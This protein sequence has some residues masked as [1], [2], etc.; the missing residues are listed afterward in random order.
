MQRLILALLI[1]S[2]LVSVSHAQEQPNTC[3]VRYLSAEH[4]Y[5]DSGTKAG[6]AVGT[7]VAIMRR[8]NTIAELEVVFAAG[9]SASCRILNQVQEIKTGDTGVFKSSGETSTTIAPAE[10]DSL[11]PPRTRKTWVSPAKAQHKPA[12]IVRGS[13]AMQWDHSNDSTERS[14]QTD[15]LS[16]PFRVL[17]ENP[18]QAWAFRAR[19]NFRHI[20]RDG[21][22]NSTESKEW[23]N[24]IREVALLR[25]NRQL[26]WHFALGRITTRATASAGPFDGLSVSRK[27][28]D[29]F[30][31]GA[32]FGYS[33]RWEDYGFSTDDQI[34][35]ANL[36]F[37]KYS[38][39]GNRLDVLLSG[40]GRYHAGE[41]SREYLVMTTTWSTVSGLSLL[42]SG[43]LDINRKWRKD[44]ENVSSVELS[45]LALTGR[46]RYNRRFSFNLGYDDRQPVRTWETQS[47]PDS[48]F[49]DAGRRGWRGGISIKLN[50]G[51]SFNLRGS[52]RSDERTGTDTKSWNGRIYWPNFLK[53]GFNTDA[54]LRGFTGPWLTG[55]SPVLGLGKSTRSGLNFRLEGGHYSYNGQ[56][57]NEQR[58]NNWLK[59]L[60]SK[61]LQQHWSLTADYRQDWGDDV[62]GQRWFLEMR[63]RF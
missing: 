1:S 28:S 12:V 8:G 15:L 16:V 31:L 35:G 54:S 23:R 38:L 7:I 56:L 53:S 33:P 32:F 37:K 22:S 42:Q 39:S 50:Q 63:Y 2:L 4:V 9:H 47:L 6:L 46:Y 5:L 13:M 25:N 44:A 41:I 19:G 24:R 14:L 62:H 29:H 11:L 34:S 10:P 26:A 30:R 36:Q 55:F 61:N 52:L 48:L 43:E 27:M 40:V 18:N 3:L 49:K 51:R 60:I 21:F 58:S 59:I 20:S 45:S 57:H 17:V